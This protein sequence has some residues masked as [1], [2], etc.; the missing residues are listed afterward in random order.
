MISAELGSTF[1]NFGERC[2]ET[3]VLQ[4]GGKVNL[5]QTFKVLFLRKIAQRSFYARWRCQEAAAALL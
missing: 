1:R 4:K 5:R 3:F 2:A